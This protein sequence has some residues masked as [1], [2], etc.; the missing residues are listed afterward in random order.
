M[1]AILFVLAMAANAPTAID[2]ER[3]FAAE[4]RRSGQ[5]SAFRHYA[6]PDAVMFTPQAVFAQDFL[7]DRKDPPKS[8]D[9][10][11]A[12]SFVSCDG[13]TAVNLGPW[14]TVEGKP[15]GTFTTVWQREGRMWRWAYDG[16]SEDPNAKLTPRNKAPTVHRARCTKAPRAPVIPPLPLTDRQAR[17]TPEDSGRGESADKTLGWD[18]KVEK[19][20]SRHF[21][22]FVW[23]GARYAQALYQNVPAK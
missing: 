7:K 1:T 17:K 5:W 20:G 14:V 22:V 9:W 13:R 11:P 12:R 3:A 23:N 6:L 15:G 10:W 4:S 16:G 21:R 2:A 18:W 19:D 8:I